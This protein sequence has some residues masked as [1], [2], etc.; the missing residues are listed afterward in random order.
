MRF[1]SPL[2]LLFLAILPLLVWAGWPSRGPGRGRELVALALRLLI[3]LCLVFSMAGLEVLSSGRNLAVVFLV[4]A[5]DSM[6][7]QALE[8]EVNYI[9]TAMDHM[10]P[11]DQAA[12]IVFGGDALVE[13]P[14]QTGRALAEITSAP[15]T[16]Q[17]DLAEAI[18][19][20]VALFPSGA[21]R[22]MIILSDGAETTGQAQPAAQLAAALGVEIIS[23]PFVTARGQ[24]ALVTQVDAP[25][26]LRPEEKFSLNVSIQSSQ[27]QKATLRVLS[28]SQVLYE[29]SHTLRRGLQTLSLPLQ[30]GGPGLISYRVQINPEQDGF[31]Q[32]NQLDA[33]S[34]VEGPPRVL[35]VAPPAGE[36]LPGGTT[37]PD[38]TSALMGALRQAGFDVQSVTPGVFPADLPSLAQYSSVVLVDVPARE[39]TT[40][41]ME[42]I[43]SY[44]R[45]LGGGLVAIGGP[46]SFG[47]GGYYDTP[48]EA[49]LP[50]DMQIKDEKRRPK[51][52]MVFII[53][54][55]GS[56][57]E[58]SG[59][60]EKVELAKEAAV[61]ALELLYPTDRVGVIQ[62]D[63]DAQ[64]VVPMTDLQNPGSVVSAIGSIRSE[65][66]TDIGAGLKAMARV[67][68]GDPATVK[69]V[70]LLTDGGADS[71]GLVQLVAGL[72]KE[73]GIT[74]STV[75]VG[76]DAAPFLKDLAVAGAGRYHFTNNPASIPSIFTE[77]TSLASRAY[78]VEETFY[79]KLVTSSPILTGIDSLPA[80]RGYIAAYP[81][82][83]AR[84]I[85]QS[86]KGD[87]VLSS[88]QYGLG[89]SVAFTSDATGRW[90]KDWVSWDQ[91]ATFWVQAVRYTLGSS[92]RVALEMNT[93]LD[94]E[95]AVLTLDAQ[96]RAGDTLN[97]YEIE[98]NLV[99]PDGQAQSV[100]LQQVAPGRY[101]GRF[102]PTEQ[103]VYLVRLSGKSDDGS[104]SF[105][106][107]TGW[108]L[109]YSPE[110]RDVQTDPDTLVRLTRQVGG[111][112][113]TGDPAEA[114]AH[115]LSTARASRPLWPWLLALAALLLPF[116]V[117]VRRLILTRYDFLLLRDRVQAWLAGLSGAVRPPAAEPQ[118]LDERLSVL[119]QARDRARSSSTTA[120]VA[121]P[122][123]PSP[124]VVTAQP[125]QPSPPPTP[126]PQ[127]A[128]PAQPSTTPNPADTVASLLARK[129]KK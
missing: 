55:S 16:T 96:N 106:E 78:I 13:R 30:A 46:T 126:R 85:L 24:E 77:E 3:A 89:R 34:V 121:P 48:L 108:V 39:L 40:R 98:A 128:A 74:L 38:E 81:K 115:T 19:L 70:I 94:G 124:P 58:S 14:M 63:D 84:V 6:P 127:A 32:N 102:V 35:V 101:R 12:I 22:R 28:G 17:T 75:G 59:G 112:L 52:G 99:A 21:A 93:E 31:Y 91:F 33:F 111:K 5:S 50:V 60:V 10:A 90:G 95:Q 7:A 100:L 9:H 41:Q 45:D 82:D 43:Q 110:Y 92:S 105:A 125:P 57:S 1:S 23:V 61:R 49:A 36:E 114:F 42:V 2:L 109:S 56:M 64:W 86:E 123:D 107:T 87:P 76:N 44:V 65:G 122:A 18:R 129:K 37:R 72:Y 29:K 119:R 97:G 27:A 83:L 120:S 26:H 113:T 69:H 71:T 118:P 66:G 80:L 104:G 4:D 79:P 8:A 88:W 11:D 103:G 73:Y 51:L 53:D 116:D 20:G 67:F 15:V 68:P 47:V 25:T 62:F 117:A 54:H